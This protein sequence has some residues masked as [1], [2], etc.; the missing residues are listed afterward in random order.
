MLRGRDG[1]QLQD[2]VAVVLQGK[3]G[4]VQGLIGVIGG[5]VILHSD[6]LNFLG[7]TT[8]TVSTAEITG[9][10]IP[11]AHM[12]NLSGVQEVSFMVDSR[13]AMGVLSGQMRALA[14]VELVQN[15][16]A[17]ISRLSE[18][19]LVQWRDV[20]SHTGVVYNELADRVALFA[21]RGGLVS[22]IGP[23]LQSGNPDLCRIPCPITD[24]DNGFW[25]SVMMKPDPKLVE[26]A[27][28]RR[29]MR[30][31]VMR[32]GSANVLT[33]HETAGSVVMR[34]KGLSASA[35]RL[36]LESQFNASGYTIIG[37]Q[38]TRREGDRRG[39]HYYMIGTSASDIGQGGCE[40]WI[41]LKL[42]PG[43]NSITVTA[44]SHRWLAVSVE[45][46]NFFCCHRCCTRTT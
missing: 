17:L 24:G 34:E 16:R 29:T 19:T 3:P 13:H 46:P 8:R 15:G 35:R 36:D 40:L 14:N 23:L 28:K 33:L 42:K 5:Q 4:D 38:E 30:P 1:A 41:A 44:Q 45:L 20:A 9:I 11:T 10:A 2:G 25:T 7:A 43:K 21:S 22:A 32:W 39:R 31:M 12:L 37:L 6:H 18:C 26:H 27:D